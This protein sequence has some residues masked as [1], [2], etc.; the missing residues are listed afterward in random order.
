MCV[1]VRA[2]ITFHPPTEAEERD[3]D[4]EREQR[5]GRAHELEFVEG[6]L[7]CTHICEIQTSSDI[8]RPIYY[9]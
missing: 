1:C 7:L 6:E 9:L 4:D 2:F 5:K 8:L 3:D